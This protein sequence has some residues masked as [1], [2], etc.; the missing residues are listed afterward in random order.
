MKFNLYTDIHA[1]YR[2]TFDILMRHEAQNMI[3]LGNVVIGNEGKDKYDWRDPANWMMATVTD[4]TGIRLTALMT[5]PHGLT[6]YATDNLID[7]T[8]ITYLIDGISDTDFALPGLMTEKNLA[9]RFIQIYSQVYGKKYIIETEMRIFELLQV[10][11]DIPKAGRLRPATDYDLYFL[12][13]WIESFYADAFAHKDNAIEIPVDIEKYRHRIPKLYV[14]EN[15]A[16]TPVSIANVGREMQTVCG[17]GSV[18]TPPYFRC[19]GYASA[20]VASLSQLQL[21]KGFTR[22]VLYTDLANPTSNSI[23]K[24]IGYMPIADSLEVKF[25]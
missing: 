8:A 10:N 6:L 19:K 7:D 3:I 5:P 25:E 4:E 1:F 16:E 17:I 18:Y 13:Y 12:P 15:E 14:W 21:D 9:E 23:Y 2:S 20:C 22:C 11:P 24:K